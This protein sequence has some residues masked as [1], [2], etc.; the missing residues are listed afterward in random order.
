MSNISKFRWVHALILLADL[1]WV[2]LGYLY[3][4]WVYDQLHSL[5]YFIVLYGKH[6]PWVSM[7]ALFTFY[8]YGLSNVSRGK[9]IQSDVFTTILSVITLNCAIALLSLFFKPFALP[10]YVYVAACM[11]QIA[12]IFLFHLIFSSLNKRLFGRK[13]VMIIGESVH[14]GRLLEH[15]VQ[16]I[17]SG[18]FEIM[19]SIHAT[20]WRESKHKLDNSDVVL[21]QLNFTD[22]E[23]I[24]GYCALKGKEVLVVP[25]LSDLFI[26]NA[27]VQH[28]DDLLVLS[29][30]PPRLNLGERFFKRFFDLVISFLLL[31]LL[32]PVFMVLF[33]WIT[34]TSSGS[35]IFT[36]I[37]SGL[38]GAEFQI[39]KF[40]TMVHDAE[41][42]SGPILAT[43]K[44]PRITRV[45]KILRATR[46]DELPQLINVLKGDMS[47]I[48]PRPE[49]PFFVNQ[50]ME[51]IPTYSYRMT[52]RP[53]ITGLAQI[54][55]KYNTS[56][57]DKH[58]FDLMYL[59]QYSFLLDI[60]ILLQTLLVVLSKEQAAGVQT[61]TTL[62]SIA[63]SA[64]KM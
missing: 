9:R 5:S 49:R 23:E 64:E 47:L 43:D 4:Y 14:A 32:S 42:L 10:S 31:V 51:I 50:F 30:K 22:K 56:A 8:L 13:K 15:K 11:V 63:E 12:L 41:S 60:K 16:N 52:M 1:A 40:R 39:Y 25:E 21:I 6:L 19:D 20:D 38:N 3:A 24:M 33:I 17:G 61:V 26:L 45:G 27:D 44:D 18:W 57:E 54:M 46:L 36:Q 58:R 59:R 35:A 34:L 48:G 62:S 53:G 55:G 37:R 28:M 7:V 2:H 29:I